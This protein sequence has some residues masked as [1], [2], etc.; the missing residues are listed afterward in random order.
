MA[1][2]E[3]S[4]RGDPHNWNSLDN[5][6]FLHEKYLAVHPFV[7]PNEWNLSFHFNYIPHSRYDEIRLEC[8]VVCTNGLILEITKIGDVD[9]TPAHRVRMFRF[10]YNAHFPGGE[11]V[12]RY[13]NMHA[14]EPDVYH[15][16]VFDPKT[17]DQTSFQALTRTQFPVMHEVLD[18]LMQMFPT[19]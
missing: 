12:L 14:E 13:D 8:V 11:N 4:P 1:E 7:L 16:H 5:Y 6:R 10:R 19:S 9:S 17:G 18:E 15:K 3:A 2:L